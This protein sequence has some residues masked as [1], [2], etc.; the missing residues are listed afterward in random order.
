MKPPLQGSSENKFYEKSHI[1]LLI[2]IHGEIW[3]DLL[4]QGM[5]QRAQSY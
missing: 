5:A 1:R 4:G 2:S 3:Q